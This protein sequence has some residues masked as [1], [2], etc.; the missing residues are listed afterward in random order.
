MITRAQVSD[1][2]T[3]SAAA[4]TQTYVLEVHAE[5]G[6]DLL[7][8]MV[9]R[10]NVRETDDAYLFGAQ[11]ND[12][13]FWVDQI[14]DRFWSFHTADLSA[15][16]A[17]SVLKSGVNSRRDI[18]WMWLPSAHLRNLWPGAVTKRVQT[19]FRGSQLVSSESPVRDLRVRLAGRNADQLLSFI[20]GSDDYRASVSFDSVQASILDPDF[21]YVEEAVARGGRFAV[22]GDSLELHLQFV[23]AVVARYRRLITLCEQRVIDFEPFDHTEDDGGGT[24]TGS[25]I[26][27]DFS[28]DIPNLED[29]LAV[30]L[31]S[32]EPFRLWGIPQIEGSHAEVEAVDLHMGQ[33]LRL[34][35]GDQWMRVYLQPHSC[36]NTV[37]RLVS[38][39]QHAFDGALSFRDPELEAALL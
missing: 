31:S 36:G 32:R 20:E 16:D 38:N 17:R 28:R 1:E 27:V 33:R 6:P 4:P 35:F 5:A 7:G 15:R 29:F 37:V 14:D 13:T 22:S 25:P 21:G 24:F 3:M 9:G 26:V 11:V 19:S 10:E 39:L 8:E 2:L 23:R 30:L 34:E 12:G 18:D